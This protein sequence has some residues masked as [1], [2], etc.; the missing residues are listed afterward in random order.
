MIKLS[1]SVWILSKDYFS[2]PK[3]GFPVTTGIMNGIKGYLWG[4]EKLVAY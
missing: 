2:S 3:F 4:L 1:C